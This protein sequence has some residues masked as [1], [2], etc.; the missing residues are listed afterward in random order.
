MPKSRKTITIKPHVE[1]QP[2]K[3]LV[4]YA[5]EK[6]SGATTYRNLALWAADF[7]TAAGMAQAHTFKT[8]KNRVESI[9][10]A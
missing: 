4:C 1:G 5:S 9:Q 6:P 3:Y 2:R 8:D 10:E 7:A